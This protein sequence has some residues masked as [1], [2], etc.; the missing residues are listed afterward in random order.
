MVVNT[1][2]VD[3]NL[4]NGAI[5]VIPG[6]HRKFYKYW[7]FALERPYR[8]GK[9][10]PMNQGDVLVRTS[11]LWHRGMPNRTS[12]ARPMV[13]MTFGEKL[14]G[15]PP[16]DPFQFNDGAIKF[17]ENW[18][19]TDWRGRLRERTVVAAPFTYAAYRFVASLVGDGGGGVAMKSRKT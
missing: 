17:Y 18:F 7:R 11:R 16:A 14:G 6:S 15:V 10:I 13:A 19:R 5:E 12:F 2:V 1:A 3:T 4:E 8:F 9:R